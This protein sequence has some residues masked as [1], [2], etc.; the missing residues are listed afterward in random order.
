MKLKLF[1]LNYRAQIILYDIMNHIILGGRV[2]FFMADKLSLMGSRFLYMQT[3]S[4]LRL[5]FRYSVIRLLR[6]YVFTVL[7]PY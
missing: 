2:L 5:N 1:R 3:V 4:L 6:S 7:P